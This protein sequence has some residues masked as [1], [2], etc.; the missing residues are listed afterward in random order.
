[1][2]SLINQVL[3]YAYYIGEKMETSTLWLNHS[4]GLIRASCCRIFWLISCPIHSVKES[5]SKPACVSLQGHTWI[6]RMET[7]EVK[8]ENH[9]L[10]APCY[11]NQGMREKYYWEK[12][13]F[14]SKWLLSQVYL[15]YLPSVLCISLPCAYCRAWP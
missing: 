12:H 9:I 10:Y 3:L 15:L 13:R 1:M 5:E 2:K 7:D 8:D 14:L 6:Q 11:T 4:A